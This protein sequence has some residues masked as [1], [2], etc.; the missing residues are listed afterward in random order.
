MRMNTRIEFFSIFFRKGYAVTLYDDIY[1]LI[2][3]IQ[4]QI[5]NKS[6]CNISII[7]DFTC[8]FT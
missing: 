6:A 2:C 3:S 8:R 7:T 4:K 5:T 1:V